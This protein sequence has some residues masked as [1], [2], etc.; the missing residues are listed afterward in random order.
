MVKNLPVNAGDVRDIGV[1]PGLGGSPGGGN[2][3][4]FQFSYLENPMNRGTWSAR[5]CRIAKS[6]I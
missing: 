2:G 4:P 3:N 1:F 6:W 5:V